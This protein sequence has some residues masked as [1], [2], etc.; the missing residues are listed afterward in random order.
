MFLLIKPM[1][2]GPVQQQSSEDE[3]IE[4]KDLHFHNSVINLDALIDEIQSSKPGKH[5]KDVSLSGSSQVI[6]DA[7]K[8]LEVEVAAS[9]KDEVPKGVVEKELVEKMKN[10]DSLNKA[11]QSLS[12][13]TNKMAD[14]KCDN[15]IS[16]VENC[17]EAIKD[18][19]EAIK[20]EEETIK[21]KQGII[22]DE[23]SKESDSWMSSVINLL[24]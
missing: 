20:F 22:K 23:N 1:L 13:T 11:L 3:V 8:V 9:S 2:L 12:D 4:E 17:K 16:S 15:S 6:A 10:F 14:E 19:L 21:D 24:G 7:E 5:P 18:D